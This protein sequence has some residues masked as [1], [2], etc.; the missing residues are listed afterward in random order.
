MRVTRKCC[1]SLFPFSFY[2]YKLDS[3]ERSTKFELRRTDLEHTLDNNTNYRERFVCYYDLQTD[4]IL[5]IFSE[6]KLLCR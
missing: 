2:R 4:P 6:I 3:G 5:Q 1:R